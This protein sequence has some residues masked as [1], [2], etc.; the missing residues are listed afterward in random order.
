MGNLFDLTGKVA[1]PSAAGST[2]LTLP[3]SP[4]P[5]PAKPPA[6]MRETRW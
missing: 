1:S 5:S 6:F 3:G 4:L 2:A